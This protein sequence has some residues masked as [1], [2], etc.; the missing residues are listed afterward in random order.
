MGSPFL[1]VYADD[2]VITGSDFMGT[3]ALKHFLREYFQTKDLG[4]LKL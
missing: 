4:K 3:G 2:I 1:L